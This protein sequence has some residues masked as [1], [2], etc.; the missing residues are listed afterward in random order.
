MEIHQ[1]LTRSTT[2]RNVLP[3]H[4]QGGV[5]AA[6]SYTRS[7]CKPGICIVTSGP[8]AINLV[9]GLADALFD[10]VPLIAIT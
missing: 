2:F 10:S 4:E 7:S 5:F 9:S 1:A 6:E 8:G 3:Y